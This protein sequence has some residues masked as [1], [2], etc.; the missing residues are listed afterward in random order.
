MNHQNKDSI[1]YL[2]VVLGA[3]SPLLSSLGQQHQLH[4]LHRYQDLLALCVHMDRLHDFQQPTD[5]EIDL[6]YLLW[7]IWI[8]NNKLFFSNFLMVNEIGIDGARIIQ[9]NMILGL[10]L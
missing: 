3:L 7:D 2:V 1:A 4:G 6:K 9:L 5:L 10:W 8:K